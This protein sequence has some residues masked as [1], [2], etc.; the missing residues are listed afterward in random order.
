MRHPARL[1]WDNP[2]HRVLAAPVVIR[3]FLVD[4]IDPFPFPPLGITEQQR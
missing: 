3:L 2:F 1:L 4:K